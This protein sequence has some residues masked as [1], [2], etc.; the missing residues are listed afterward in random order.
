MKG[1]R[2]PLEKIESLLKKGKIERAETLC[3]K[4]IEREP[5]NKRAL[6]LKSRIYELKKD[7]DEA[8]E[9]L[10]K[11]LRVDPNDISASEAYSRIIR[12][13]DG[14][15]ERKV[16]KFPIPREVGKGALDKDVVEGGVILQVLDEFVGKEHDLEKG[17]WKGKKEKN[18]ESNDDEPS[19]FIGNPFISKIRSL[20]RGLVIRITPLFRSLSHNY[21][22][23]F[24][25]P[26]FIVFLCLFFLLLI[27]LILQ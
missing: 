14:T 5:S 2:I 12:M 4:I 27:I 23:Y 26:F 7:Y 22:R 10:R 18:V 11:I 21:S 17:F 9:Y 24:P 20:T 16:V 13:A 19:T 6:L 8:L 15:F 1:T 3:N 25:L